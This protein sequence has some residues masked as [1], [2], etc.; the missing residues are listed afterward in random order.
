MSS[1]END[2]S[3]IK[4][5]Q[6]YGIL[7]TT[8]KC[9]KCGMNVDRV[10]TRKR[11]KCGAEIISWRCLK[12]QA[13]KSIRDGSFFSLYKTSIP[14][15]VQIIKFWCIQLTLVKSNEL[16]ILEGQHKLKKSDNVVSSRLIGNVYRHLRSVCSQS[17][18]Q[19]SL[20]LGGDGKFVEIDE[21]L[22]AKVKYNVGKA[23]GVEQIWLF[24]LVERGKNGFTNNDYFRLV[25]YILFI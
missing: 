23:L 25:Y 9:T 1:N 14:I 6:S 20:K 17:M 16:L 12:C 15:I 18:L 21:S 13:Y 24:G 11:D 3:L 10:V 19:R 7:K 4:K 22:V 5:L 8:I 2:Y